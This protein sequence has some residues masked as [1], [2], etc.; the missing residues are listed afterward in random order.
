MCVKLVPTPCAPV[1][2][3]LWQPLHQSA[4]FGKMPPA[5]LPVTEHLA[6]QGLSLPSSADL[7]SADQA[8][9]IAAIAETP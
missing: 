6:A 8:R 7:S 2:S 3:P 5:S 9:V 1:V 4:A